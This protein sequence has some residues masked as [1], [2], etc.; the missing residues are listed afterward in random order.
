MSKSRGS[1]SPRPP[2]AQ[3]SFLG[4]VPLLKTAGNVLQLLLS[5]EKIKMPVS[6]TLYLGYTVVSVTYS[7]QNLDPG[8][9]RS[10]NRVQRLLRR[11][12]AQSSVRFSREGGISTEDV[13]SLFCFEKDAD[14][15]NDSQS[16]LVL[17][18]SMEWNE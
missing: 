3:A 4:L 16:T 10:P 2:L 17:D 5:L 12:V 18:K 14:F 8:K 11:F 13:D 7:R 9:K 15:K 6:L 1:P